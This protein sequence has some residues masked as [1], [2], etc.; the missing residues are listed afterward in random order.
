MWWKTMAMAE[1][2]MPQTT[3]MSA[4]KNDDH[5]RRI[6]VKVHPDH[7]DEFREHLRASSTVKRS[8][9]W[10]MSSELWRQIRKLDIE[11]TRCS[12]TSC[13]WWPG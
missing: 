10:V 3:D 1:N 11:K 2:Q 6:T 5:W 8:Y 12:H 7:L 4:R 13:F 9:A